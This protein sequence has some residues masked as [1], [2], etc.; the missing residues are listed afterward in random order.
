MPATVQV[1]L[2]YRLRCEHAIISHSRGPR[3]LYFSQSYL[4]EQP[5]TCSRRLPATL[6][7]DA[8]LFE[9]ARHAVDIRARMSCSE[10]AR[11]LDT[12][13]N[14]NVVI[15]PAVATTA[16]GA[17]SARQRAAIRWAT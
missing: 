2:Q 10:C 3:P 13:E 11:V 4:T 8:H 15:L 14:P 9:D 7:I 17:L 16:A 5:E 6:N 12:N 1:A